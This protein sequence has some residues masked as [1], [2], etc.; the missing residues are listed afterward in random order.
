MQDTI[1]A[2]K[3]WTRVLKKDGILF[4]LLPHADRIFDRFRNKTTL[5]HHILDHQNLNSSLDY[6]HNKEIIEGWSKLWNSEEERKEIFKEYEDK[7]NSEFW[8]F[9]FRLANGIIH[10]HVWTQ[11]EI[12][13][14]LQ[15]LN[16]QILWTC[17]F[18]PERH[19]TFVVIARKA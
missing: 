7:W 10:F 15:Y 17:E 6:S 8:D 16:L 1:G 5:E 4:L 14:L 18:I 13:K 2:L 11:D 9:D 19:D 3:E 12:V